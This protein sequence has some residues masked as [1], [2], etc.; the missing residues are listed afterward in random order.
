MNKTEKLNWPNCDIHSSSAEYA[1]RFS[2]SAGEFFLER[3]SEIIEKII[4]DAKNFSVL[5]VGGGHGQIL[6]Q[7]SQYTKDITILGS[8]LTSSTL[9]TNEIEKGVCNFKVG[10]FYDLPFNSNSFDY[11]ISLRQVAHVEDSKFTEVRLVIP[12]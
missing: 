2:G 12:A 7:L 3:Q 1:K 11:V 5:D 10:N 4:G 9:I 8:E 6:K